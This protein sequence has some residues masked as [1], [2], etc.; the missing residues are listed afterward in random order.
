[1]SQRIRIKFFGSVA[2]LLL[3]KSACYATA[4][5][6]GPKVRWPADRR[7]SSLIPAEYIL[8]AVAS[9]RL[10]IPLSLM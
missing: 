7:L 9:A 3:L 10:H 5:R 4:F 6:Q 8:R 1:M 2:V